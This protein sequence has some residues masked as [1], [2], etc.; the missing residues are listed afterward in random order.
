MHTRTILNLTLII[1][2]VSKITVYSFKQMLKKIGFE[3]DAL[4]LFLVFTA[5]CLADLG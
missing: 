4:G 5:P 2:C 1:S 3:T